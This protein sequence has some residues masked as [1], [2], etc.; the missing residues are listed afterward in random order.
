MRSIMSNMDSM[1]FKLESE[2]RRDQT[3]HYKQ[4][5]QLKRLKE[6]AS[7][8]R[9]KILNTRIPQYFGQDEKRLM[10]EK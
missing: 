6:L 1:L 4:Q 3:L 8:K 7:K 2:K 5:I 10:T 9:L